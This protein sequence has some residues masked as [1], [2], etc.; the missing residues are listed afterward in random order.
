MAYGLKD[1]TLKSIL[2]ILSGQ[3]KVN[4]I[5]LLG[6]RAMNNY[7][8]NSDIDIAIS[9]PGLTHREYLK[10]WRQLQ[11]LPILN[12]IDLFDL[13]KTNDRDLLDH[14]ERKGITLWKRKE[15][16]AGYLPK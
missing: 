5:V 7:R 8:E 6:S 9:A 2:D 15:K 16:D 12:K 1:N 14:I 10:L 3:E 11:D 4:E 13:S